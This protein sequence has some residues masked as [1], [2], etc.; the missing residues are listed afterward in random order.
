MFNQNQFKIMKKILVL[1]SILFINAILHAQTEVNSTW[2]NQI[3]PVFQGLNKTN[4]PNAILLD[5]AMEFTNVPAYNGTLTDSTYIDANV[6]GNIYKTLF[7]GKVT[8]STQYFPKMETIATNWNTHRRSY[9][10]TEQ[11]TLVLAGLFYQYSRINSNALANGKITVSNNKYYD[12]YVN[13]IWQNPYETLKTLAFT[14]AVNTYNKKSF[15]IILPQNMWLTNSDSQISQIQLNCNDGSG[16][17][18]ISNYQK[19]FANYTTNGVYDWVFK[20]TLTNGTT[21]Y[22]HTKIKIEEN[23]TT[24]SWDDRHQ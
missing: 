7:M 2:K 16:Y 14:P 24:K 17:K 1:I 5:Y 23:F 22:S 4:V 20:V 21:L 18:T 9:N 13:G 19:V 10:Q 6:L 11:S 8:T 15:G 12:K 3:N